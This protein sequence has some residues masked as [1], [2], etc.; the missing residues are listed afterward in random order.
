VTESHDCR[1]RDVEPKA[2]AEAGRRSEMP[3]LR[4]GPRDGVRRHAWPSREGPSQGKGGPKQASRETCWR[5][6][7]L[8]CRYLVA[9]A[10]VVVSHGGSGGGSH[11]V[12]SSRVGMVAALVLLVVVVVASRRGVAVA[13]VAV[14]VLVESRASF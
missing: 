9:V 5:C 6:V 7:L 3:P 2:E 8:S 4:K 10:V 14:M 12:A 1:A 13:A 11:I